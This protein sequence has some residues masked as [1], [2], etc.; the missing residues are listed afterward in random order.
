MK[1]GNTVFRTASYALS[2][3]DH[4]GTHVDAPKHFD[5]TPGALSVDQ[6]P[7]ENFYTEGIALDL[8]HVELGAAI[9]V[10]EM[11]EALQKSGEKIKEGDTGGCPASPS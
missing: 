5:A 4:A 9:A 10:P 2:F 3:S 6:M 1:A 8:S 11:E 7:L